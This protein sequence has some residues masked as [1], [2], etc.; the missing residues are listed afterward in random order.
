MARQRNWW[1]RDLQRL[2]LL[3]KKALRAHLSFQKPPHVVGKDVILHPKFYPVLSRGVRFV[4][5]PRTKTPS[6]ILQS[7][8][9]TIRN[10]HVKN[11]FAGYDQDAFHDAAPFPTPPTWAR[12]PRRPGWDPRR[13]S[14]VA[15]DYCATD[16]YAALQQFEEQARLHLKQQLAS[17]DTTLRLHRP[18]NVPPGFLKLATELKRHPTIIV[19]PA[20]KN[21]GLCVSSREFYRRHV[22]LHLHDVETYTPEPL[23]ASAFRKFVL[24]RYSS[25]LQRFRRR[26]PWHGLFPD[27]TQR[28]LA[29]PVSGQMRTHVPHFYVLWKIHKPTLSTRPLAAA[30]AWVT[31]NLS[32]LVGWYLLQMQRTIPQIL[33][34][35]RQLVKR[36]DNLLLPPNLTFFTFDVKSLYP[37]IPHNLGLQAVEFMMET[38]TQW[39]TTLRDFI[40]RSLRFILNHSAVQFDGSVYRQTRGTAMGTN[41]AVSYAN[42]FLAWLW[43]DTWGRTI[44]ETE[45]NGDGT[46]LRQGFP[47]YFRTRFVDD[48]FTIATRGFGRYIAGQLNRVHRSIQVTFQEGDKLPFLDLMIMKVNNRVRFAPYSKPFNQHLY[49]HYS[50]YHR[51]AQLLA[52]LK[53]ELLRR[54][55]ASSTKST[56]YTSVMEFFSHCQARGYPTRVL[57]R[58][59]AGIT[60]N[61]RTA[62]LHNTNNPNNPTIASKLLLEPRSALVS[63]S[64]SLTT[65]QHTLPN[66]LRNIRFVDAFIP[67]RSLH[68]FVMSF[69]E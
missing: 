67:G 6:S 22:L 69:K 25:L 32:R 64:K 43:K 40:L 63:V 26:Q 52:W 9:S 31:T 62:V 3:T 53:A 2:K 56:F 33:D 49:L 8:N 41:M 34:D 60:F 42:L 13:D 5:V 16:D 28:F 18:R 15:P 38:Y 1:R 36:L 50:S 68:S 48:I 7:F 51:K 57:H 19:R 46:I 27:A 54:L 61:R 24:A 14:K 37:N 21:L 4:P 35:S 20:D 30:Y 10:L 29:A 58:A 39:P 12:S 47:V 66:H 55:V 59:L 45:W 65:F 23:N 17:A 44:V 11:F